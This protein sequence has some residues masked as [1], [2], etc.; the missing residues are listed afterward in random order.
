MV[1]TLRDDLTFEGNN[2]IEAFLGLREPLLD[3]NDVIYAWRKK[4]SRNALN[5]TELNYHT[6]WGKLMQVIDKIEGQ[7]GNVEISTYGTMITIGGEMSETR[8][9]MINTDYDTFHGADNKINNTYKAVIDY[10]KW[11]KN[12]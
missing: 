7:G 4:G 2:K 10:I 8:G 11:Y 9:V 1:S 12:N 5:Y 3:V 6:D